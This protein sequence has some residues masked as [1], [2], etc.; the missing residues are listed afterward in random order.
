[1]R[2]SEIS[3]RLDKILIYKELKMRCEEDVSLASVLALVHSI[4]EDAISLSKA[5][6]LN[7][8]IHCMMKIIFTICCIWQGK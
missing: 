4:G 2:D 1:M 7:M 6:I 8:P 3:S 5:I